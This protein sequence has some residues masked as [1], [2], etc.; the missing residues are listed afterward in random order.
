MTW[1]WAVAI[2]LAGILTGGLAVA[3]Y[4]AYDFSDGFRNWG[5]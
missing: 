5:P 2:G 1:Y 3:V 4:L